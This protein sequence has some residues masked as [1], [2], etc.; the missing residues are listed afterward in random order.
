MYENRFYRDSYRGDELAYFDV[1]VS[2]TD[3]RVGAKRNLYDIA[4]G[5]AALYH[6]QIREYIRNDPYFLTS[7]VPVSPQAGAPEIVVKMCVA[8]AAA[9]VGPMAA[10]AGAIGE[11]VGRIL[12]KHSPEVIVE[13]GGDIFLRSCHNRRIG[14]YAGKSPLSGRLALSVQPAASPRGICTSAGTVGHSLSFGRADAAVII[15][16]DTYLADAVAT[17]TGNR[18]K[19]QADINAAIE[20]AAGISG[21][22]GV[23]IVIGD[24][25]GAWGDVELAEL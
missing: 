21:V 25:L 4:Y 17:A 10:V 14:I 19:S 6:A 20:F 12:L 22:T 3:L 9:G 5:A 23:L 2:E 18:V 8:A 1:R 24:K 11:E 16:G 7:L 15:A 13:N